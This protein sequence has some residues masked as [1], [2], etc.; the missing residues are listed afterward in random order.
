MSCVFHFF[1]VALALGTLL[2]L[3]SCLIQ[4]LKWQIIRI[5]KIMVNQVVVQYQTIPNK[6]VDD[7]DVIEHVYE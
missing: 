4:F 5:A 7:Y 3:A 1:G 2:L 6:E